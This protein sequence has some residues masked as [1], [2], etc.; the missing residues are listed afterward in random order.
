M[1]IDTSV[2]KIDPPGLI[3]MLAGGGIAAVVI[4]SVGVFLLVVP[5]VGWVVGPALMIAAGLIAL[6]HVGGIFSR[7]ASYTGHCPSCG[8][9]V[10]IGEPGS[11]G[12][13]PECKS[14]F[15]H[16]NS[17]LRKIEPIT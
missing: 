15:V 10:T 4:F 9:A 2:K 7:K 6:A 11:A 3:E 5:I 12:V 8:A 13:C 1:T 14:T 17:Q 16:R